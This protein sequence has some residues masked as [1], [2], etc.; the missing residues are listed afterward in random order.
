[1]K[2]DGSKHASTAEP[3][4]SRQN[5]ST[6]LLQFQMWEAQ[7]ESILPDRFYSYIDKTSEKQVFTQNPMI[8]RGTTV[9]FSNPKNAYITFDYKL[10]ASQASVAL[11]FDLVDALNRRANAN[12]TE[13]VSRIIGNLLTTS[14]WKTAILAWDPQAE[15]YDLTTPMPADISYDNGKLLLY[16]RYIPNWFGVPSY[17]SE[18]IVPGRELAVERLC[19]VAISIFPDG[20]G[21]TETAT[22]TIRN[23]RMGAGDF[24]DYNMVRVTKTGTGNGTISGN[25]RYKTGDSVVLKAIANSNSEFRGWQENGATISTDIIYTFTANGDRNLTAVF[26]K[27]NP[28][29]TVSANLADAGI[30]RGSGTYLEG[31][32][33][34]VT[35][36]AYFGYKFVNW[37]E[38]GVIVSYNARYLFTVWQSRNLVATFQATDTSNIEMQNGIAIIPDSV[39]AQVVWAAVENAAGYILIIKNSNN[40]L[41]CSLE[42]DAFGRLT[43]LN[44]GSGLKSQDSMLGICITNLSANTSYNY[45]LK[46]L[47][48]NSAVLETKTG[49]FTTK[50]SNITAAPTV[51]KNNLVV[52][53]NP[54]KG[55]ISIN[56]EQLTIN[57]VVTVYSSIGTVVGTFVCTP[58]NNIIDI[59]H[60][61]NG[62]Y[63]VQVNGQKVKVVKQ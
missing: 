14:E 44:F 51:E 23:I 53:P 6:I 31:E 30:V 46:A 57:N 54:T 37:K 25:G 61:P 11:Q 9:D 42:F 3:I 40:E 17:P 50:N 35:A 34:E 52:Y 59:S 15:D 4:P 43:G 19:G 49:T 28:K 48:E 24:G 5:W 39:S 60:L 56:S 1:M 22:F 2:Y 27:V 32:I 29:I 13:G 18:G 38:N 7:D 47:G 58:N 55:L 8:M 21:I 12:E 20:T 16:D 63:F 36:M 62:V 45:S 41:V 26:E 33:A 10:S